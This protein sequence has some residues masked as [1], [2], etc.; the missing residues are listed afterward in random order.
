MSSVPTADDGRG[1]TTPGV[2]GVMPGICAGVCAAAAGVDGGGA[3]VFRNVVSPTAGV[4]IG[5]AVVIAVGLWNFYRGIS[6]K[7]EDKWR[8]GEMS[9]T[10]RRWGGR[11]GTAGHVARAVVFGLTGVFVIKAALFGV[12]AALLMLP[13]GSEK[14]FSK[15]RPWS[16][17][18]DERGEDN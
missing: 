11:A 6:R 13:D 2:A 15:S 12:H 1:A 7:F 4:G 18:Q 14:P 8:T 16:H 5:G 17:S 10:A 3:G 9:P